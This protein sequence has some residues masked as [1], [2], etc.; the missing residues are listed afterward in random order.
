MT[1]PELLIDEKIIM[2]STDDTLTLTNFRVKCERANGQVSTYQ[3]IPLAKISACALTTKKH[4]L[5]LL[6]AFLC[7]VGIALTNPYQQ[8]VRIVLIIAS[9]AFLLAYIFIRNGQLEVHSDAGFKIA[10][11]TKG[12]KHE[13]SRKFVEAIASVI[14]K[15]R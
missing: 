15:F 14:S 5:L 11:P 6:I 3:S 2:S 10:V 8:D 1:K 4:P 12:L 9:L 13:E 7:L